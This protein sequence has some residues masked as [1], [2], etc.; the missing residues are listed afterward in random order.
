MYTIGKKLGEGSFG[1]VYSGF[2]QNQKVAIKKSKKVQPQELEIMSTIKGTHIVKIFATEQSNDDTTIIMEECGQSLSELDAL[3]L[4]TKID[5]FKQCLQGLYELHS[6]GVAH[7]DIKPANILVC[8]QT[9][10][11]IDFGL[12]T[13]KPLHNRCSGTIKYMAPEVLIPGLKLYDPFAADIFGL[14][15][16]MIKFLTGV[17]ISQLFDYKY[18]IR[19]ITGE[20]KDDSRGY[21]LVNKIKVNKL[22]SK[23]PEKIV[24]ILSR[25]L[26]IE[27]VD[28]PTI[29]EL[30]LDQAW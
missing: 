27:P 28:R 13:Y 17:Y 11:Y 1:V 25:M 8:N 4:E 23:L 16:T 26:A 21:H 18:N 6:Q 14:G 5:Y 30:I 15:A 3:P 7:M 10:K 22:A 24:N 29:Y 20:K 12:S 9:I 2:Y 19:S